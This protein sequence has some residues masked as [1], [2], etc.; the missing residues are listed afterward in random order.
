[1]S[2][3]ISGKIKS[4][5]KAMELIELL[6]QRRNPMSLQEIA[7]ASGYPKSTVHGLLAT[8]CA[9]RVVQQGDDGRYGLGVFLFECGCA[10]SAGWDI[11]VAA[12]PHLEQ[13]AAKTGG[14]TYIALLDGDSALSFDR[15]IGSGGLQ[16][17]PELG[18]RMPLHATAQGK[19]LLAQMKDKQ[20][21]KVLQ[22]SGMQAYT[23]HTII[24][25][26]KLLLSLQEIRR[27]DLAVEDGEYKI[28][29]RSA[30]APVR[31]R[32][33]QVRYALGIV[34]LYRKVQCD[35]FQQ[36]LMQLQMQARQLSRAI[37]WMGTI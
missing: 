7:E 11:T 8:L 10:V 13:L 27:N 9:H 2:E 29:L 32:F 21:L 34:G 28:G 14:S 18:S 30:A 36:A 4:V 3:R 19:L 24:D 22:H 5:D 15:C 35:E 12:R 6:L 37:G 33:G 16:V 31:D 26:Q 1:M 17:I 23:P 25:P 20:V